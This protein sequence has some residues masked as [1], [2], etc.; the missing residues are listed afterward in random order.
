MVLRKIGK[1]KSNKRT[2]SFK[3]TKERACGIAFLS[4]IIALQE[5]AVHE[6]GNAVV[7]IYSITKHKPYQSAEKFNCLAGRAIVNVALM[8]TI[9]KLP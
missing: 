2:N 7:D 3:K 6:G 8:G 1:Y 5:R 9:V 4:A